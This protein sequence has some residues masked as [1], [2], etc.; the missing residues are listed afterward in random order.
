MPPE[1]IDSIT[2]AWP[3]SSPTDSNA[4]TLPRLL[5]EA[6]QRPSTAIPSAKKRPVLIAN[7]LEPSES[8]IGTPQPVLNSLRVVQ[9]QLATEAVHAPRFATRYWLSDYSFQATYDNTDINTLS[10]SPNV[11]RLFGVTSTGGS[12]SKHTLVTVNGVYKDIAGNEIPGSA[13]NTD[14]AG[15]DFVGI[16]ASAMTG[17]FIIQALNTIVG[18]EAGASSHEIAIGT[19]TAAVAAAAPRFPRLVAAMREGRIRGR[20][21]PTAG[22]RVI[23][24]EPDPEPATEADQIGFGRSG[25]APADRPRRRRR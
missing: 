21:L 17:S 5:Q 13:L 16:L 24:A 3:P 14:I 12:V 7:I 10:G 25:A 9:Q 19:N 6:L 8:P 2:M 18:S 20:G 22:A 11:Q 4:R 23:R 15:T 1:V